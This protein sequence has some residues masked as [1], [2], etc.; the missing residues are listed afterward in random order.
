MNMPQQEDK[1]SQVTQ[2]GTAQ[3]G[4]VICERIV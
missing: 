1:K 4:D 3:M 2:I